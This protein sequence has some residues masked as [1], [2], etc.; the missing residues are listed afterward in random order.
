MKRAFAAHAWFPRVAS[1][2]DGIA[3]GDATGQNKSQSAVK[4]EGS[5]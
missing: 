2:A 5:V 1:E 4:G 3:N